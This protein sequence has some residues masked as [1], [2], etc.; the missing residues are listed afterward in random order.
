VAKLDFNAL[1]TEFVAKENT[2][3][4]H[5]NLSGKQR[6]L[7]QRMTKLAIQ[8]EHNIHKKESITT[9]KKI[10]KLYDTTLK[11]FK[12]GDDS[13]GLSKATDS[14]ILEQIST[15]EALWKPFY[16]EVQILSSGKETQKVTKE[17]TQYMIQ[18]NE[19]LLKASDTLVQRYEAINSSKDYL[20]K[21]RLHM[22][23]VAGR[24]R[25]LTQKMTK[26]KLLT[27][28]GDKTNLPK[29]QKSIA[30]FDTSLQALMHG[31][32]AQDILMPSNNKV[33][34]QLNIVSTLWSELKP[35]YEKENLTEAEV[36]S[37]IS[38]NPQLL[39]EMNSMVE[40]S[41]TALEY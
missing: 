9:L 16:K 23:N 3:K 2:L 35:L 18:N 20:E 22:I 5:I 13:L 19:K 28:H 7:T 17:A 32:K 33:I 36:E 14:S 38:K 4:R 31:D 6:M 10:S 29:L 30:L 8:I 12:N 25:M 11:G 27:L 37:I 41:E 1:I 21:I 39:K 15:I 24:Q 40:L 34:N 26:E